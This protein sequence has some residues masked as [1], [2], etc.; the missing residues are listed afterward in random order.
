MSL[1][2]WQSG[3][4]VESFIYA[5]APMATKAEGNHHLIYRRA[6]MGDRDEE[7]ID[8]VVGEDVVAS[9]NVRHIATIRW[10]Q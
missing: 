2:A 7:W 4:E 9:H 8:A 6:H 5:G 1:E 10:K 3:A